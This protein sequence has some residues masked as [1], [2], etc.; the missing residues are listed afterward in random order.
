MVNPEHLWY[1][2]GLITA[3]GNL[4]IDG[5]HINLTSKDRDLLESVKASMHLKN[6]IGM[7]ARAN[8]R[9]KKY[10]VLQFGDVNF[11]KF[12][13]G[14]GLMPR[15][16][17]VLK[18]LQVPKEYFIDFLRGVIDGDGSIHTWVHATNGI[19]QWSLRIASAS[20][21]FAKWLKLRIEDTF[22]VK[23][24]IYAIRKQEKGNYLYLMKFGKLPAQVI[25]AGCYYKNCLAL[26]RKLK[27]AIKCVKSR[28]GLSKYGN[29]IQA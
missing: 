23:G 20:P 29:I 28:R 7:K 24:K 27:K 25:L 14:I 9:E 12:L 21:V 6:R 19:R 18:E 11:Y 15:K 26:E 16:S 4:S 2:I 10:A 17:L 22:S 3:D 1:V 8:E 13:L 5:R